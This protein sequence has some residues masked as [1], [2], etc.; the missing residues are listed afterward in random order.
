MAKIVAYQTE[1]TSIDHIDNSDYIK[2]SY[3]GPTVQA[4]ERNKVDYSKFRNETNEIFIDL[5]SV[6]YLMK[7]MRQ[8]VARY[9]QQ[10]LSKIN[11]LKNAF[12]TEVKLE[13]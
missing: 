8:V 3:R 6:P 5:Y 2:I 12:N 11:T 7:Q 13:Q 1:C 10:Q 9:E 4:I